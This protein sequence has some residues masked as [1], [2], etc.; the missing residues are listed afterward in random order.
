MPRPAHGAKLK[1]TLGPATLTFYGLGNIL[2]AGIYVLIGIMAGHAGMLT[3]V[4]FIAAALIALFSVL[5]YA[6]LASRFPLSGGEA[7]YVQEGLRIATLSRLVGLLVAASGVVAT[8]TLVRGVHGYVL[9][10]IDLP[11]WMV[12]LT[13]VAII[14]MLV[15]WGISQSATIA[16]TLTLV[17]IGGLLMV[18]WA[19]G[20]N[21]Y[22]LPEHI[23]ELTPG[24]E[25]EAWAAIVPAAFLA[26]F[27]FLG[28]EDMVSVAEEV[29][30]PER[31]LP[32]SI[33][34]ALS[35]ATALYL[36]VSLVAVLNIDPDRLAA[37]D[38]PLALVF[39]E[40][41]GFEPHVLSLIGI[42]AV[43]NGALVSLI[44]SSRIL[45]GMAHRGLLWRWL[46]EV[47]PL[48]NTPVRSTLLVICA[49]LILAWWLPVEKLA[50]GTSF[51]ILGVF[52]L[53][54]AS[55]IAIKLR[56][57][58]PVGTKRYPIWVPLCGLFSCLGLAISALML[59]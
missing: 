50:A 54:N 42:L 49:T 20:D 4:A 25:T 57:R 6:E 2:G 19:G 12:V 10:F 36:L 13:V 52:A 32:L 3:P 41:T 45:Y 7:I 38:A 43:A 5:T 40:A 47:H 34:L 18:I 44:R 58:S 23:D 16:A 22:L 15:L 39:K 48:T 46:S 37:S 17:E 1:R 33:M 56:E 59:G 29:K 26:F 27:A 8:A 21:L 51:L 35:L 9:T 55:L 11:F 24:L 53:V 14:G 28:F 30:H 31:N